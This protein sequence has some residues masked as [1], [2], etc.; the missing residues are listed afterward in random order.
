MFVAMLAAVT[1]TDLRKRRIPNR[2]LGAAVL[3]GLPLL[4][5]AE[6]ASLPTRLAATLLA[7]GAFLALALVRPDGFGMGDVKLIAAMG[8]FLGPGV[9]GAVLV[10]LF[11]ASLLGLVLVV[12]DGISATKATIP[13]GPFLALGG[14]LA[15][16]GGR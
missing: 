1:I 9:L 4:A 5:A 14:L 15:L 6:P 10:A 16:I 11:G 13:F 2:V 12:R 8:L 7:G 3:V